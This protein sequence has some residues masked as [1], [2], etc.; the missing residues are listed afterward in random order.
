MKKININVKLLCLLLISALSFSLLAGCGSGKASGGSEAS[1]DGAAEDDAAWQEQYA[2]GIQCLSEQRY[3]EAVIAFSAAI[4]IK[5]NS[6]GSYVSRADAYYEW[7]YSLLDEKQQ[8]KVTLSDIP[9]QLTDEAAEKYEMASADYEKARDIDSAAQGADRN[10]IADTALADYYRENGNEEKAQ[11]YEDKAQTLID[12]NKVSDE[13]AELIE[14]H[15]QESDTNGGGAESDTVYLLTESLWE[16]FQRANSE[17]TVYTY[18]DNG[19][20]IREDNYT[21]YDIDKQ[22]EMLT[23]IV[24]YTLDDAGNVL[25]ETKKYPDTGEVL[26]KKTYTYDAQ[27]YKIAELSETAQS[28]HYDVNTEYRYDAAGRLMKEISYYERYDNCTWID[29]EYNEEG[30][31]VKVMEWSIDGYDEASIETSS[32][33]MLLNWRTY[34]Y[35]EEGVLINIFY[36]DS[37]GEDSGLMSEEAYDSYGNLTSHISY[38]YDSDPLLI[39]FENTY[40]TYGNLLEQ[41]ELEDGQIMIG[42]KTNTWQVLQK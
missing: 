23:T 33:G 13:I 14:N 29:Y 1:E 31:L 36:Y 35:N 22:E 11:E 10:A 7:G 18:D 41:V 27:G 42:R 28:E 24:E 3:E 5:P 37:T 26:L 40:D 34:A 6:S 19:C 25:S 12:E 15:D 4:D 2:L 32:G 16:P 39:T 8:Q 17:K 20:L 30:N 9:D 21:V 38:S